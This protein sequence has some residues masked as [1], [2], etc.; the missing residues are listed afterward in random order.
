MYGEVREGANLVLSS[1]GTIEK[2]LGKHEEKSQICLL[3]HE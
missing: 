2:Y 1:F 3:S